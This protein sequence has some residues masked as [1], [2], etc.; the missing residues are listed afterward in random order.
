MTE[1]FPKSIRLCKRH[2]YQRLCN[3]THRYAGEWLFIDCR[4]NNLLYTRLGITVTRRYGKAHDRNRFKRLVRE[5]F[6]LC[7]DK[8]QPGF[9]I[10]IKPRSTAKKGSMINYQQ[11]LMRFLKFN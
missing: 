5:A 6:R 2:Q 9:D 11:D 4:I 10:V 1:K 7:Q 3:P 8:L